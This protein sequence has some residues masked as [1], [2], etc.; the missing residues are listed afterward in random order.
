MSNSPC[1]EENK[2]QYKIGKYLKQN[3]TRVRYMKIFA[4]S[5]TKQK[6]NMLPNSYLRKKERN[7]QTSFKEKA[8]E[9]NQFL[10]NLQQKI[11]KVMFGKLIKYINPLPISGENR[12]YQYQ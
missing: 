5:L 9:R 8:K 6:E 10:S 4:Y 3:N 11:N 12:N 1:L 2:L 7:I